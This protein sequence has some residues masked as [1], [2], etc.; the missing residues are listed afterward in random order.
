M[1][2]LAVFAS[3][4]GSNFQSIIDKV[5]DKSLRAEIALLI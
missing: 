1:I 2:R 3:G 4:G 5:R